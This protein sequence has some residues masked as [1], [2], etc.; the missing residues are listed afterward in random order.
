M[1]WSVLLVAPLALC[2]IVALLFGII[3][4]LYSMIES[5][6]DFDWFGLLLGSLLFLF[7]LGVPLAL[8]YGWLHQ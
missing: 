7:S 6:F 3:D 1:D 2:V 8:L 4:G 5:F